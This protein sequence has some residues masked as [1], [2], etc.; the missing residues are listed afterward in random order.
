[1]PQFL[2][3]AVDVTDDMDRALGQR[4]DGRK[5]RDLCHGR[6]NIGK[7]FSERPE[8]GQGLV[9]RIGHGFG[10]GRD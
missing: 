9:G 7:L 2:V 6:V 4:T 8:K 5:P 1:M 3:L 10:C